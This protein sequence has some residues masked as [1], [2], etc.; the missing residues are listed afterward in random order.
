MEFR[1]HSSAREVDP[2]PA[3]DRLASS[4]SLV[5]QRAV[6]IDAVVSPRSTANSV[7]DNGDVNRPPE[8]ASYSARKALP[9]AVPATYAV[10]QAHWKLNPPIR[11]SQS[12]ISPTR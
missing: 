12:R 4:V 7:D 3:P 10:D 9:A 1:P 2:L 5:P 11:P 6:D 8:V